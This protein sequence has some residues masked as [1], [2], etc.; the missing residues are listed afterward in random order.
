MFRGIFGVDFVVDYDS[1]E[2]Y[3]MEINPRLTGSTTIS[4]QTYQAQ[5][6]QFP[7]ALFHFA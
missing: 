7:L 4:F 5:G 2:V 1:S 3:F 6:I